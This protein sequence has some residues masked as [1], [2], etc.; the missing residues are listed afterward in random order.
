MALLQ[1]FE[2]INMSVP[3]GKSIMTVTDS[4]VRF[5][6][7][8]A[9]DLGYPAYVKI[10]INDKTRQIALQVC[11]AKNGNAVKFSKPEGKQTTSVNIKDAVVLDALHKYF[12]LPE[13]PEGEVAYQSVPR[14]RACRGEDHHL[15]CGCGDIRHHEEARSQE[16]R[17]S[18]R[19][20]NRQC[21]RT[22]IVRG[23]LLCSF[24]EEDATKGEE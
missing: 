22:V 5:N 21:P 12:T 19:S 18:V 17:L 1:G 24:A 9:A 16:E 14:C 15:R 2:E 13:A 23:T 11:T 3:T 7:A 8:T 20:M 4:V 10:L 6:K